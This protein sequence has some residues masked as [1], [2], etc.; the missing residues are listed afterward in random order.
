MTVTTDE[1]SY[2]APALADH[3]TLPALEL[4]GLYKHSRGDTLV[5]DVDLTVAQGATVGIMCPADDERGALVQLASGR[6]EPDRGAVFVFGHRPGDRSDVAAAAGAQA[7]TTPSLPW[8]WTARDWI[9]AVSLFYG[10]DPMFAAIRAE[11]LLGSWYLAEAESITVGEFC[12]GMVAKVGLAAAVAT[13]PRLLLVD[14]PFAGIDD[15]SAVDVEAIL[16]DF[17]EAGGT[18]VVSDRA[19]SPL[20]RVCDDVVVIDNGRVA[21]AGNRCAA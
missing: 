7:A 4:V 5:H 19:L 11:Q 10:A 12:P 2:D 9:T 18:V 13:A 20:E 6:V 16:T 1:P 8:H 17:V 3:H 14:E 21:T 15:E